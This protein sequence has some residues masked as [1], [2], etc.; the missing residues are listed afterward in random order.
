[1]EKID[2]I[3]IID[4]EKIKRDWNKTKEKIDKIPTIDLYEYNKSRGIVNYV[5]VKDSDKNERIK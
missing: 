5:L 2:K 4:L 1:M 3:P